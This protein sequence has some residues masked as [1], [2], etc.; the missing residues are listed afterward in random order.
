MA[1]TPHCCTSCS[2][3]CRPSPEQ[4]CDCQQ[5]HGVYCCMCL[6]AGIVANNAS[7]MCCGVANNTYNTLDHM[8]IVFVDGT[9]LDTADQASCD[10]FVKVGSR[11]IGQG[12]GNPKGVRCL[13]TLQRYFHWAGQ[14]SSSWMQ[15]SSESTIS[16]VIDVAVSCDGSRCTK[17]QPYTAPCPCNPAFAALHVLSCTCLVPVCRAT[18]SCVLL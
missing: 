12:D 10:S 9:L 2:G 17:R 5:K 6:T 11:C 7:G 13:E 16:K 15:V 4:R 14:C 3:H 18:P 1:K 8:R